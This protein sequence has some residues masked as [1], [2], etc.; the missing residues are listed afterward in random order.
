VTPANITLDDSPQGEPGSVTRLYSGSEEIDI[1]PYY[2]GIIDVR[3]TRHV[4]L[5]STFTSTGVA[6]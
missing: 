6:Q 3:C 5:L 1:K 2:F 4:I